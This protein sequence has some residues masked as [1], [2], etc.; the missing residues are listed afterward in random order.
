MN[1]KKRN[2]TM[3]NN[4]VFVGMIWESVKKEVVNTYPH[5]RLRVFKGDNCL[6][7]MDHHQ[8]RLNV[9]LNDEG[10]ITKINFG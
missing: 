8:D 2:I 4:L 7:T 1:Q 10:I 9:H 6:A 3:N 5:T